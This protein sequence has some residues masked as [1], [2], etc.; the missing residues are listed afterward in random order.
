MNDDPALNAE[1]LDVIERLGGTAKA[2]ELC[3]VSAAAVSQWRRNGVPKHQ[4]KF[5]RLARP[6]VFAP[7]P[8]LGNEPHLTDPV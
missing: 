2:A 8:E 5:I 4:L 7:K 6:D 3:V 1:A